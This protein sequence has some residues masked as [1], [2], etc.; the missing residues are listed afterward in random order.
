M[1]QLRAQISTTRAADYS[2]NCV[3]AAQP[4]P[5]STQKSNTSSLLSALF[6]AAPT[7]S[8]PLL[9][10]FL[11]CPL[12]HHFYITFRTVLVFYFISENRG[13][14]KNTS[15]LSVF[16]HHLK[17]WTLQEFILKFLHL[18]L[19]LPIILYL[20]TGTSWAALRRSTKQGWHLHWGN[21]SL[22][23]SQSPLG[24]QMEGNSW[25]NWKLNWL[26]PFI[27]YNNAHPE[28]RGEQT[29]LPAWASG[30]FFKQ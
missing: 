22:R 6:T 30:V 21:N 29:S 23:V 26:R 24:L 7:T 15:Q 27:N 16:S 12:I 5:S 10:R 4:S 3:G 11:C 8:Q 18:H 17:C 9:H 13:K 20:W 28:G 19:A 1:P 14:L 25:S 2:P